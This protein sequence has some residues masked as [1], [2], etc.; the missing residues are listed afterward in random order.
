MPPLFTVTVPV[1]VKVSVIVAVLS[2]SVVSALV[3]REPLIVTDALL[4]KVKVIGLVTLMLPWNWTVTE[5]CQATRMRA[6]AY[7]QRK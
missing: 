4:M 6:Y 1:E 5:S 2:A 3:V 7:E